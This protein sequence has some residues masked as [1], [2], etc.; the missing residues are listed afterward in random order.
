VAVLKGGVSQE[1][2]VSLRSGAAVARGLRE[3][4]YAVEEVDVHEPRLDL[5]AGV[6][7]VFIAL[8]GA[9]GEDGGVQAALR[10]AGLPYTGSDPEASRLAFDKHASKVR[11]QAAGVPT[12]AWELLGPGESRTLPLPV[13]VKPRRQG[14]SF[15]VH[16]VFRETDWPAALSDALGYGSSALVEV[17]VDGQEL[18][19]GLV[20]DEALPVIEIRA[21][22]GDYD[23][24]AKYTAGLTQYLAPAPLAEADARLARDTAL[25]TFRALGGRGLGRVD[26]RRNPAGEVFV[27]ELNTI[28]GFTETSLLPKA[29]AAAGIGFSEL[30]CRIMESAML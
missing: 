25:A 11:L 29:A 16:R 18:T 26:L 4:G 6:E 8:H 3:G 9:F 20:G 7:A 30:C 10:E 14:S 17:F 5:P 15:G 28:P 23:Y 12:P 22:Q 1:R 21:P 13:V 19:V 24:R 2:E 27:L